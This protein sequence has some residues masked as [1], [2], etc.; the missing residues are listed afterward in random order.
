MRLPETTRQAA[1][2]DADPRDSESTEIIDLASRTSY[3]AVAN[4][5]GRSDALG[6]AAGVGF[7]ALLGAATL[8][9]LNASRMKEETAPGDGAVQTASVDHSAQT[10]AGYAPTLIDDLPGADEGT[11]GGYGPVADPAPSPVLAREPGGQPGYNPTANPY[12]SPTLVFDGGTAPTSAAN[13]AAAAEQAMA[14]TPEG[15][16]V[17]GGGAA[18]EFAARVGGV[19]GGPAIARRD[20]N[21]ATTVTQGTMI[22]AILETAINTDV[23]GFVRAVVSQDVRSFDGSRVLIPRSSRLV[24]QYQS[25]LQAGQ[26][27]A[28]VIWT[29]V[30]RPD[31]VTVSLQSPATS[32]DGT[33]GL[34]GDVDSHFFSRFG[35]AMLLSVIG[36]LSNLATG[37]ASVVLGGGQS[38][39]NTALQQD[40]QRSPTVRV[41]MG[42][43][44]R[45][46]TA[47]DLDF[48][49]APRAR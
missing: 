46:Y 40:G 21:P 10:Q 38:A 45:V 7:V 32:F 34:R 17:P 8:W 41:R 19:G 23:P 9:G 48:G 29:R 16:V 11:A 3:P 47:R 36:G 12:S 33:A 20:V 24:G 35:S 28:Y 27:R 1:A 14:T 18:G 4:R 26:R 44:I 2:N 13:A 43:P 15:S 6:L 42:E 30:I 22:P 25:G 37:G 5:K 31:G 49:Q 39:A